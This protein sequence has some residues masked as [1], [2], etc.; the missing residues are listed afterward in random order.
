MEQAIIDTMF[1]CRKNYYMLMVNIKC[2]CFT[3]INACIND[4]FKVLNNPTI[5]GWHASMSIM[6]IL[7]QL[8]IYMAS[9]PPQRWRGKI[10]IFAAHILQQIPQKSSSV[11]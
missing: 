9:P 3:A 5:Q 11:E 10:P 8:S 4:A 2:A 1:P 7:D 6:S